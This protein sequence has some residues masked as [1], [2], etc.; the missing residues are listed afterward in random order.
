M[1]VV[2]NEVV[3]MVEVVVAVVVV[4]VDV[5]VVVDLEVVAEEGVDV[6][7]LVVVVVKGVDVTKLVVATAEVMDAEVDATET[8]ETVPGVTVEVVSGIVVVGVVVSK[9][10]KDKSLIE[11][12]TCSCTLNVI[13]RKISDSVRIECRLQKASKFES[14]PGCLFVYSGQQSRRTE[15]KK[16]FGL[17]ICLYAV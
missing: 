14:Q 10:S 16:L 2:V 12:K 17:F 4:V 11:S 8:V 5:K 9:S 1:G 6:T 15:K 3:D 7:E 13:G